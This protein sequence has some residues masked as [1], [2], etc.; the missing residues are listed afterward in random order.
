MDSGDVEAPFRP[1]LGKD[2]NEERALYGATF[3]MLS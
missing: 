1:R 3:M 2:I